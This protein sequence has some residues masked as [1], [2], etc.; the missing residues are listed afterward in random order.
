MLGRRPARA[1]LERA[2][3]AVKAAQPKVR[4]S[5]PNVRGYLVN[6]ERVGSWP[7]GKEVTPEE[8]VAGVGGDHELT[9]AHIQRLIDLG[10]VTPL[11]S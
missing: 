10:A 1:T 3:E 2:L 4:K 6:H 7:R 8:M 9:E 5:T 11:E